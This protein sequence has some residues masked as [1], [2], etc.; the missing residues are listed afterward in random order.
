MPSTN[1]ARGLYITMRL[2][3]AFV[4]ASL[5]IGGGAARAH[6]TERNFWP[7]W[8]EETDSAGRTAEWHGLGPLAFE[9]PQVGGSAGGFRPLYVWWKNSAQ[10]TTDASALYPLFTYHSGLAVSRW[11]VF[12]MINHASP[13]P[14]SGDTEHAFDFW[15]FYFSRQTGDP[16]TSYRA[17]FPL[18]G[19][20]KNRFG[21]DRWT[22]YV[23]PLYGRYEKNGVTTT[24]TPWPFVK[25]MRGDGN[26]GFELWPLFGRREK[27]GAYREQY[28]LWPFVYKNEEDLW[29]RQPTVKLGV[30]PFYT[31]DQAPGSISEDYFWPFFGYT[32][33]T[34][35]HRYHER[36]YFWPMFVQ[37]HGDDREVNR[38]GPFYT[39]SIVA[40]RDKT[41]VLWPLWRQ[42]RSNEDGRAQTKTTVLYFFYWS[43]VQRSLAHP[44]LKPARRTSLWPLFTVWNSGDRRQMEVL[45]PFESWFSNNE[46]IRLAYSPFFAIFRYDRKGPD[47]VREDFLFNFITWQRAP[48]RRE[49]HFGPLFQTETT[50]A[51]SRVAL[52]DG[53]VGL[54]RGPDSGWRLFA[55]DFSR[56]PAKTDRTTR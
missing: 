54:R 11:S 29:A 15:P 56:K 13:R 1:G 53:L 44:E 8:V 10:G 16:A 14:G 52:F 3:Y 2:L 20:M 41:W 4:A 9:K 55:F 5:M 28:Y 49:F 24:T 46:N 36:R 21:Q 47:A 43:V 31:R 35:P 33:R 39:H 45:S 34:A 51:G 50:P 42:I 48:A 32:D 12:S 25:V 7:F 23:F 30:L 26:R 6:A 17:V 38:W 19:T 22:F 18:A 27:A 37:G 40:G